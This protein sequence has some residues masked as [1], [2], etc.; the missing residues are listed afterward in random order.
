MLY[1]FMLWGQSARVW[2][3]AF[4]YTLLVLIVLA[5]LPLSLK[6]ISDIYTKTTSPDLIKILENT[7]KLHMLSG[8][9]LAIGLI[10][11]L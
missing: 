8:L 10:A 6:L 9:L 5:A 11:G 1:A 3:V 7:A 4:L 2:L